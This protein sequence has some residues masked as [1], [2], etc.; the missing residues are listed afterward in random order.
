MQA[1]SSARVTAWAK[2][3]Q[4]KYRRRERLCLAEGEKVV[5]ELLRSPWAVQAVLVAEDA[6][7]RYQALVASLPS[8]SVHAVPARFWK[9]LSQ[10]PAP[11]GI[12]AVAALPPPLAA[13]ARAPG[14]GPL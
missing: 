8:G 6:A 14:P 4:T 1:L 5:R 3:N 7:A 11:E 13:A 2:L 9:R 12:M 10:D